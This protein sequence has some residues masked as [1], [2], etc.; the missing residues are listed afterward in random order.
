MKLHSFE[1]PGWAVDKGEPVVGV[2]GDSNFL[3]QTSQVVAEGKPNLTGEN[4]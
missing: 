1:V 4:A 3:E 2:T